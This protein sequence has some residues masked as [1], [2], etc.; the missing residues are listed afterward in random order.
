MCKKDLSECA[1]V[2]F[3]DFIS[4]KTYMNGHLKQALHHSQAY[5]LSIYVHIL[6]KSLDGNNVFKELL[7]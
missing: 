2:D 7:H 1:H 3:S 4:K 5:I 6:K